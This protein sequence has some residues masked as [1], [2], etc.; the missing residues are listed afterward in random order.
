MSYKA[1][2]P[3]KK[4]KKKKTGIIVTVVITCV[5]VCLAVGG[6]VLYKAQKGNIDAVRYAAGKSSDEINDEIRRQERE[7][8]ERMSEIAG[9]S[10]RPLTEEE[11]KLLA[12]GEITEE[13]AIAL[14]TGEATLEE[15]QSGEYVPPAEEQ[16]GAGEDGSASGEAVSSDNGSSEETAA[17]ESGG[18]DSGSSNSAAS[19]SN[20]S[21][22]ISTILGK[23]YLLQS[24]FTGSVESLIDQARSEAGSMSRSE[25]MRKYSSLAA[26]LE[27][28]CD[29]R[30]E[31]L[32]GEL[33]AAGADAGTVAEVRSA[34][35]NEKSLKKAEL[36]SRFSD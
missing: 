7:N 25:L 4:R 26:S 18:S 27:S 22:N 16:A 35:E 11:S 21:G 9:A 33:E 19:S 28:S 3:N 17:S 34:Y 14:V 24:E 10:M 8:Q 2:D 13:E 31:G 32:L 15:I 12:D 29:A 1:Y 36:I 6:V 20:S 23:I 5:I 30:M